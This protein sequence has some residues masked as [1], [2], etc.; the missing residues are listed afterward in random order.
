VNKLGGMLTRSVLVKRSGKGELPL[1]ARENHL[2]K[3]TI[4]KVLALSNHG[5]RFDLAFMAEVAL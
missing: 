4:A 2:I 1:S 3:L 5:A